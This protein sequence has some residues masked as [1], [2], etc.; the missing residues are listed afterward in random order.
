MVAEKVEVERLIF[1]DETGTN[2]S[3]SAV[4]AWVP[5]GQRTCWSVPRN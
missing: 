3:L 5:K 1:V 2:T 4:H